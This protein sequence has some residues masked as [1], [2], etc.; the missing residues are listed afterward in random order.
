[1][2]AVLMSFEGES[3]KFSME[4]FAG[5]DVRMTFSSVNWN[6]VYIE[7]FNNFKSTIRPQFFLFFQ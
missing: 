2:L 4:I 6:Q 7:L 3:L 1:V 5:E